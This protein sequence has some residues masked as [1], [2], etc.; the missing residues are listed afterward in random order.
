MNCWLETIG[1]IL[2]TLSGI[3]LG[4]V[5]SGLRKPYWMLG[6]LASFLLVAMLV[7][8]RFF[9]GLSFVAP[10]SWIAAG[11]ARFVVLS[12]AATMGLTTPLPR[13]A[14]R[15]Q[16]LAVC[17]LMTVIVVWFSISPFLAPALLKN[18]LLNLDTR[19]ASNGICFQ[20]TDYTCGPA[21][22]VT[23]LTKL[24]LPAQ[25][26][27]IAVLSHCSPVTGTLPAC[28]A[29]ALQN[30]YGSEGLQCHYRRFDSLDE[31]KNADAALAVVSDAFLTYHCVAVLEVSD[32]N[33]IIADPVIGR[34]SMSHKQFEK[35][36]RYCGIVLK[37]DSTQNKKG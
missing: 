36:W 31:L 9:D 15:Y 8:A 17:V 28:L 21:A 20:T 2:V 14:N 19:I 18:R 4:R 27:E 5:F 26:G 23:A 16:K 33:V 25:E 13:L 7:T 3:F 32:R 6:Y 29:K 30:R 1:V 22:A 37:R 11:R 35:I 10:L 34:Q 24:G 12:L